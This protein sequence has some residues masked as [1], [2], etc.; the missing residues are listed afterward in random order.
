MRLRR[1]FPQV[2]TLVKAHAVLHAH[3]RVKD[4]QGRIIA[5]LEDYRVVYNLVADLVAYGTGQKVAATVRDTV[6]AVKALVGDAKD[7]PGVT[8]QELA[9]HLV[10]DKSAA[11]RRAKAALRAGYLENKEPRKNAPYKLVLGQP[12]PDNQG[13]LPL[14]DK[15][16]IIIY[17]PENSATL[18][19]TNDYTDKSYTYVLHPHLQ[20][21]CNLQPSKGLHGCNISKHPAIL[22]A[23]VNTAKLL[24]KDGTVAGLH[25]NRG[26]IDEEKISTSGAG[27]KRYLVREEP[28]SAYMLRALQ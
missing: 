7:H 23:T 19:P 15:I 26:G 16:G 21:P 8:V 10:R 11:S 4:D 6:A 25:R 13:V 18:Q 5:T 24:E 12:L 14:P 1:D 28:P 27:M 20:P 2:L 3:H 22:D 17:P 9:K